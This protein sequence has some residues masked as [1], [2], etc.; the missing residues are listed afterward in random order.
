MHSCLVGRVQKKPHLEAAY[1]MTFWIFQIKISS[2]SLLSALLAYPPQT[3]RP[4]QY[5]SVLTS[6]LPHLAI[7]V[8][9]DSLTLFIYLFIEFSYPTFP[10]LREPVQ[11]AC[12]LSILFFHFVSI[13]CAFLYLTISYCFV[14]I[15]K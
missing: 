13:L 1:V 6:F 15:I 8:R 2:F 5:I 7:P 9:S 11:S 10:M 12:L 14:F 4:I 3:V